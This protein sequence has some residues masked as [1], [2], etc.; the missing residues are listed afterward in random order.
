MAARLRR[1]EA[2]SGVKNGKGKGAQGKKG[3]SAAGSVPAAEGDSVIENCVRGVM[4][5]KALSSLGNVL[6]PHAQ[7]ELCSS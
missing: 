5:M 7:H 1:L 3:K 4:E 2:V 6:K